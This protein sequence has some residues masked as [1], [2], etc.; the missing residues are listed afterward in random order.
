[1]EG[2]YISHYTNPAQYQ[3]SIANHG[4]NITV[5]K[6]IVLK[7]TCKDMNRGGMFSVVQPTSNMKNRK[8]LLA[9]MIVMLFAV[10]AAISGINKLPTPEPNLSRPK[11]VAI[12][13]QSESILSEDNSISQG[14]ANNNTSDSVAVPTATDGAII[15]DDQQRVISAKGISYPLRSYEALSI[16]NDPN[17]NQ[18]WVQNIDLDE[19][20]DIPE[21][22]NPTTI[23]IIDTGYALKHQEFTGRWYQNNGEKGATVSESASDLNCTDQSIALTKACNN[24]DDDSDGIND[25][26]SGATS[27]QN[28]SF[29]NCTD[30]NQSLD[31]SCNRIDD[32]NNG[33]IDDLTGW[34]FING[35]SSVQAGETNPNE[36]NAS[37]GSYVAGVAAAN[38]N[39]NV[40][41][42]GVSSNSTI[43][44]IQALA[45]TGSGHTLSVARSVDYAADKG[46]DIISLSLGTDLSDAYLQDSILNA[47]SKGSV[48]VA[49]SG[50]NGCNCV[51]YPANYEEVVA[52]GASNS[53]NNPYSFSNY[54]ANLDVLAPGAGFY[55]TKWS[56]ANQN[57]DYASNIAGTSL[58]TPVV[59]GLL[60]RMRSY[61][62]NASTTEL[63]AAMTENTLRT[64]LTTA[65][66]DTR[67]FGIVKAYSSV[68]R[69]LSPYTPPVTYEFSPVSSGETLGIE[70]T[71]DVHKVR[72]YDCGTY[73]EFGTSPLYQITSSDTKYFTSSYAE[74][75]ASLNAGSSSQFL[76]RVC[77]LQTHDRPQL[78]RIINP[79]IEFRNIL[80]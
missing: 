43:L 46:A 40:G 74:R 59:S 22:N 61:A 60:A 65:H 28:V 12:N 78:L 10:F 44:P 54:G 64:G 37:H 16:P 51:S 20:W 71:K 17:A 6:P 21:G 72:S 48:V 39:N 79:L 31:K 36:S 62:P 25:N 3:I 1:M 11:S 77:I 23:A 32:D 76:A 52:V 9:S 50:N 70:T 69:L 24:I 68:A 35:D 4:E 66:A 8:T 29:L 34:D 30:S 73:G 57:S 7:L 27:N 14:K 67:G 58:A 41:L 42:A 56:V 47:I 38:S 13:E 18:W 19:A 55:T 49:A 2:R 26:E 45:D 33:Y 5:I 15:S 53:S 63:I 75:A 80:Q